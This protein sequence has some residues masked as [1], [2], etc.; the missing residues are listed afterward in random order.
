MKSEMEVSTDWIYCCLSKLKAVDLTFS[1]SLSHFSYYS[2]DFHFHF[3]FLEL[4]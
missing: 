2:F 3:L 1:Y 4:G